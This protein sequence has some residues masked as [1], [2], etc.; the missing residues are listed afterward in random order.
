MTRCPFNNPCDVARKLLAD[1]DELQREIERLRGTI[2][3]QEQIIT[4]YRDK[5]ER[6]EAKALSAP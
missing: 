1:R 5:V 4:I 3:A 6:L 2:S